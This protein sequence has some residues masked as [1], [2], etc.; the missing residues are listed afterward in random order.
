MAIEPDNRHLARDGLAMLDKLVLAR[1]FHGAEAQQQGVKSERA[2]DARFFPGLAGLADHAGD[3]HQRPLGPGLRRLCGKLQ[4]GA[5]KADIADLELRRVHSDGEPAR[6][7][8][9][10][11][12]RE[13]AL[14][15]AIE[16]ALFVERQGMCRQDS[17]IAENAQHLAR[18]VAPVHTLH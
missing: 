15:D 5:I 3:H 17:A 8:I 2:G 4:H 9:D 11:V 16:P 14:R 13:G 10:V 18:Q 6:S 12:A 1:P 7:R